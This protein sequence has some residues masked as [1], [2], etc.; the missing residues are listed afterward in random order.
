MEGFT[1]GVFAGAGGGA[2]LRFQQ[3]DSPASNNKTEEKRKGNKRTNVKEN[4]VSF[5]AT[6]QHK[7]CFNF[8]NFSLRMVCPVAKAPVEN[9]TPFLGGGMKGRSPG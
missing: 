1:F 3:P 5:P 8:C 7:V 2:W 6:E 4:C 9:P